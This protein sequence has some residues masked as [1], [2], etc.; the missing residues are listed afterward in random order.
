MSRTSYGTPMQALEL[1]TAADSPEVLCKALN[2][3]GWLLQRQHRFR[4]AADTFERLVEVARDNDI[5]KAQLM[6]RGNLADVRAQADL[7]GAEA[8]HLAAL[9]AGRD[10]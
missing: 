1:A 10:G 4:E 9:E 6:G 2:A 3:K 8:E 7:P 5:P